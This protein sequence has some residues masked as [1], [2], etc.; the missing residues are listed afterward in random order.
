[1]RVWLITVNYGDPTPTTNLLASLQACQRSS[2][3]IQMG[4]ADN[5]SQD[6]NYNKLNKLIIA[7]DVE[8]ELFPFSINQ[9]QTINLIY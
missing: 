2:L 5:A 7:S 3:R 1:M 8:I 4:I 9:C 6:A